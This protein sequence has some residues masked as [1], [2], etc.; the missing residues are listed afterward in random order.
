MRH[1]LLAFAV[2]ALLT[3]CSSQT[4]PAATSAPVATADTAAADTA[5]AAFGKRALED[6]M[7]LSPVSATQIGDHRF[8][9]ELDDL[10][11]TGRKAALDANKALLAE[12]QAIDATKLSRENQVDAAILRNALESSIWEAEVMQGWAWRQLATVSKWWMRLTGP[13]PKPEPLRWAANC[14][15][16][17]T[18]TP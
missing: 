10:S 6:W 2:T 11:T 18:T 4:P 7:R 13:P 9:A 1:T 12:L 14:R 3:A 16:G 17:R 5:F 15:P 8:D